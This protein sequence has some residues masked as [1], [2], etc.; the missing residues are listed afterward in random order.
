M[1]EE[2]TVTLYLAG[3]QKR[4]IKDHVPSTMSIEKINKI[5][6]AGR[7][8]KKEW[9]MY[10][11]VDPAS[12]QKGAWHLYLTDEQINRVKEEMNIKT[13]ISALNISPEMLKAGTIAFD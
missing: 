10:I 1:S 12:A 6:I 3:W 8:P 5:K 4:M 9:R 2:K 11:P 7:I 13:S